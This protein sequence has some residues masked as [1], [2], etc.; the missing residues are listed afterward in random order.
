MQEHNDGEGSM[1]V[2]AP[3]F[4]NNNNSSDSSQRGGTAVQ[5]DGSARAYG[6]VERFYRL[7]DYISIHKFTRLTFFYAELQGVYDFS[8]CIYKNLETAHAE[9]TCPTRCYTPE[10]GQN[11]INLGDIFNDE[12][13]S[14]GIIAFRQ[15][16]GLSEVRNMRIFDEP[17]VSIFD[18]N[19][20]C[21]DP[22]AMRS[23]RRGCI[24]LD[25]YSS[26][27]GG[28]VQGPYDTCISCLSPSEECS[29]SSNTL[30]SP[31][32][33]QLQRESCALVRQTCIQ[34]FLLFIVFFF[35][36]EYPQFFTLNE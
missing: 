8:I 2:G 25:G 28:K 29:Y 6:K 12:M 23:A 13:T 32:S 15:V 1:I 7:S 20:L 17:V 18:E 21:I 36:K 27:N 3:V 26:S 33:L 16:R 34:T 31:G 19:D 5:V 14:I 11:T 30:L 22:N 35:P 24:C 9:N 4:F 10:D